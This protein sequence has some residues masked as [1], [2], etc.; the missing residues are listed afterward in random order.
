MGVEQ[1]DHQRSAPLQLNSLW[2]STGSTLKSSGLASSS[3]LKPSS[4]GFPCSIPNDREQTEARILPLTRGKARCWTQ[5]LPLQH[6]SC[7]AP[8]QWGG[9]P[10]STDVPVLGE[11]GTWVLQKELMEKLRSNPTFQHFILNYLEY[12][13]L[14][15]HSSSLHPSPHRIQEM[16][17]EF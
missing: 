4:H 7:R 11:W 2:D 1:K 8:S 3:L 14:L 16:S 6:S 10:R 12:K 9:M 13:R 15:H 5:H 17:L